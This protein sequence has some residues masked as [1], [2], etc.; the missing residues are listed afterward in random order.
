MTGDRHWRE[1]SALVT[2][3]EELA[4]HRLDESRQVKK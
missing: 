3:V 1:H 4:N 2:L